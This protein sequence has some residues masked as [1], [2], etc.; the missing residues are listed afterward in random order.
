MFCWYRSC[1]LRNRIKKQKCLLIP[2]TRG[3][4]VLRDDLE[5]ELVLFHVELLELLS[6]RQNVFQALLNVFVGFFHLIPKKQVIADSVMGL[7][8]IVLLDFLGENFLLKLNVLT[9]LLVA[10]LNECF[11]LLLVLV[12]QLEHALVDQLLSH[13]L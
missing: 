11:H 8:H 4:L 13:Y 2:K 6:D 1:C 5:Y 3:F 12:Q 9:F 10:L 7:R